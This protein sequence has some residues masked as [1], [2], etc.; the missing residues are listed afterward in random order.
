MSQFKNKIN[1]LKI[2]WE[3]SHNFMNAEKVKSNCVFMHFQEWL[4]CY[5]KC[6]CI[7]KQTGERQGINNKFEV[8]NNYPNK[9]CIEIVLRSN[10][11]VNECH[12]FKSEKE[13]I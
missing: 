12:E 7:K 2:K 13:C 5:V 9:T 3:L 10:H 4:L 6:I 1:Y 8:F 11:Q